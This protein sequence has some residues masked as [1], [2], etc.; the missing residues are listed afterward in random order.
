[1][2]SGIRYPDKI[3]GFI[4]NV[5]TMDA[6]WQRKRM[7]EAFPKTDRK[8]KSRKITTTRTQ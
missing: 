8:L 1:M 4:L 3:I 5:K 2:L 6:L 7:H